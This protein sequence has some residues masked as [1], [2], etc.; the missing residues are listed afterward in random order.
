[1]HRNVGQIIASIPRDYDLIVIEEE[2]IPLVASMTKDYEIWLVVTGGL[3]GFFLLLAG[4]ILYATACQ[5]KRRRIAE[6]EEMYG[7]QGYMGWN[8]LRLKREVGRME[9][10]AVASEKN[11]LKKV[12]PKMVVQKSY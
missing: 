1:M 6:L 8:L 10:E 11:F 3:I 12:E 7:Q 5:W 2:K 9:M 4:A